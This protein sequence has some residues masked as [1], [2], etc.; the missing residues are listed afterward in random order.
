MRSRI[1]SLP[2]LVLLAAALPGGAQTQPPPGGEK[3]ASVEG[4]VRNMLSGLP[5]ERAH[6]SLRRFSN[7]G[8]E[9]YGALT[10]A[11]G[12]FAILGIPAGDYQVAM[13]RVGYVVPAEVVRGQLSL[14]PAE[15][16]DNY[17]PKLI[18]VATNSP[19]APNAAP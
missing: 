4:E 16:K 6:V 12:K 7:S 15:K 19:A 10:N 5:V 13:V 14:R 1:N 3:P 11:E 17:K 18:P 8:V 9:R 2:L